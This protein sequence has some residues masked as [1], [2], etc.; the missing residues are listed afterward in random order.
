MP[1]ETLRKGGEMPKAL[2]AIAV[3]LGSVE[4]AQCQFRTDTSSYQLAPQPSPLETIGRIQQLELQRQ[5]IEMQRLQIE[6][7]RLQMQQAEERQQQL[8]FER[9][10]AQARTPPATRAKPGKPLKLSPN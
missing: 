6:Q 7:Q 10:Q 9:Q 2:F 5:Q 4:A 8:E 3:L 1:S